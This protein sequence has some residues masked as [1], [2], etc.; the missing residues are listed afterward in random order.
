MSRL[1]AALQGNLE[2]YL[3]DEAA[4]VAEGSRKAVAGIIDDLKGQARAVV[5]A[6]FPKGSRWR[7]GNRRLANAIRS[8]V[9]PVGEGGAIT[10]TVASLAV[11]RTERGLVDVL[12]SHTTGAT[13]RARG[14]GLMFV[15]LERGGAFGVRRR[16]AARRLFGAA[17]ARGEVTIRR[18]ESGGFGIYRRLKRGGTGKLLAML[19]PQSKHRARLDFSQVA[20]AAERDSSSRVVSEIDLALLSK[21]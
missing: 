4:A 12:A 13:I 18:W 19:I 21:G 3:A 5:I 20:R 14:G 10:G 15:N 6:G 11:R 8:R 1:R 17:Q 7:G 9:W 16:N 2:V